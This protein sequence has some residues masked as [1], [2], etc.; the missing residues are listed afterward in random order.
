MDRAGNL[1]GTLYG[2][3][4]RC[5]CGAVFEL[6]PPAVGQAAWTETVLFS[7]TQDSKEKNGSNP[8]AGLI[9]DAAGNLYGTTN[10]G[11]AYNAG[12]VFELSPPAPGKIAWVETVLFSFKG[13]AGGLPEAVLTFDAAGNLYGTTTLFGQYDQ[14]NVFKLIPPVAGATAWTETVLLSF[15]VESESGFINLQEPAASLTF[16]ASGGLYGTASSLGGSVVFK[17]TPPRP[18][19][20]T[21]TP[22]AVFVSP[23]KGGYNLQDGLVFDAWGNLYGVASNGGQYNYGNVFELT[24]PAPGK[25]T[26]TETILFSFNKAGGGYPAGGLVF[27]KAGNLYGVTSR[28]GIS[29]YGVVF[30]LSPPAAGHAAWT[31]TVLSSFNGGADGAYPQAG[32]VL[33]ANGNLYGT[34]SGGGTFGGGTAFKITP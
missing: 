5:G 34:T 15:G 20:A 30:K 13:F 12:V 2:G 4:S 16:D 28:G 8:R 11:G 17:L 32:L 19:E 27:D 10:Y 1:Y 23:S 26:W 14:G 18:G 21:W 7:F 6:I 29:N 24:P 31:E 3:G 9:F 33:D 22:T 25:T